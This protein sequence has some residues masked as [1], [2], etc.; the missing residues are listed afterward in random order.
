NPLPHPEP[1]WLYP[2]T[3][4]ASSLLVLDGA[5]LEGGGALVRTALVM[6]AA[7]QQG[8]QIDD[9]RGGTRHPGLDPEDVVLLMAVAAACRAET[10]GVAIG[11]K[12]FTFRPTIR[13]IKIE[14]TLP[15][16]RTENNRG[17]NAAVSL[18]T[19]AP[20]LARAS[21]YSSVIATGETYG[22]RVLGYD[23][24]AGPVAELWRELGLYTYF[25]LGRAG[26]G[27]T[28]DGEITMEVEPSALKG[29]EWIDRGKLRSIKAAI[30]YKGHS[31]AADRCLS[32]L[33]RLATNTGLKIEGDL[34]E[35]GAADHGMHLTIWARYDKGLGTGAA[36]AARGMR[37]EG[38]AQQAF[39]ELFSWM[40]TPATL[41]PYLADHILLPAVLAEGTTSFRTNRL[42]RRFLTKVWV[43]KQFTPLHITVRGSEDGPGHVTIQ[44]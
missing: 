10:T 35:V 20:I 16:I 33:Q 13:A 36:T 43:V 32:H 7:T 21:A 18:A 24:L 14:D 23:A 17:S 6:S 42:T 4:A 37:A 15:D 3:L 39:E 40:S 25:E 9:V 44:R 26:F 22:M 31:A 2:Q 29:I 11:S 8:F 28:S 12:S 19:L 5:H 27:R 41:D 1:V 30:A 34:I 38:V